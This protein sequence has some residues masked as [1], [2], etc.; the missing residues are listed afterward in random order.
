MNKGQTMEVR[1]KSML[2][3][4]KLNENTISTLMGLVVVMLAA[5]MIFNYFR[6]ANLNSWK[7]LIDGGNTAEVTPTNDIDDT[8]LPKTHKVVKGEDL[9]HI[10]EKY[11]KSGYNYVDLIKANKL[12]KNGIIYSGMELSIPNVEAKKLTVVSKGSEANSF[13][14]TN[15]VSTSKSIEPGEYLTVKGDSYWKIA[16]K[17]YG[18]G[19]AWT[20]IYQANKKVFAN[21]NIITAGVKIVIPS[22]K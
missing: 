8:T 4:L 12:N 1:V 19:Y 3:I 11:Y 2:K 10:S 16:V 13:E 7:G 17:A 5:G 20:K 15:D 22:L 18:D 21:A 6:T 14:I 9:W